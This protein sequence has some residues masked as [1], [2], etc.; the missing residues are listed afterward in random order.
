MPGWKLLAGPLLRRADPKR[1]CVWIATD[2]RL[3]C[4]VEIVDLGDADGPSGRPEVIGDS[5]EGEGTTEKS[6]GRE[7]GGQRTIRLGERL[8]VTLLSA[9]PYGDAFPQD[10]LLGYDLVIEG[11]RLADLGLLSGPERLAYGDLPLPTFFLASRT[12]SLLHGSCRNLGGSG[13]DALPG[14]DELLARHA[15]R[16]DLR[17]SILILDGDQV[18]ADHLPAPLIQHLTRL[19]TELMGWEE[20]IPGIPRKLAEIPVDG[21][22]ELATEKAGFTSQSAQNQLMAFGEY[23]ALSLVAWNRANWP[24]A[25]PPFPDSEAG[26]EDSPLGKA[27]EA[28]GHVLGLSRTPEQAYEEMVRKLERVREQVPAVRRLLANIPTYMIFDDHDMT[29]DLFLTR[30]W[31]DD[32]WA[33][34]TGRRI[35]ANGLA[36][37]WAFQ[38]WGS[39]PDLYP[40]AF[41]EAVCTHFAQR[42]SDEAAARAFEETLWHEAEWCFHVPV[43]P[44]T[45]VLDTRTRR[46]YDDAE[47]AARLINEEG[48]QSMARAAQR[49]GY[50]RGDP[51]VLVSPTPVVGYETVEG[52]Q[53]LVSRYVG[54]YRFDLE[55]WRAN[56]D[57]YTSFLQ[58][59]ISEFAPENVVFLAGD[60][61]YGFT[62]T[63]TFTW[64]GYT[65]PMLQLTSSALKNTGLAL[66][67]VEVGSGLAG[68]TDRH[69]GWDQVAEDLGEAESGAARD[70]EE[71]GD[72]GGPGRSIHV[73]RGTPA[74]MP[75]NLPRAAVPEAP[76]ATEGR[77]TPHWQ[78]ART[79]EPTWGF[80]SQPIVGE[81]NLG[82]VRFRDGNLLVHRLLI[83][84][85]GGTRSSTA[86]AHMKP[87]PLVV[88]PAEPGD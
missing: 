33:S 67:V 24:E 69:F 68:R 10:R 30:K 16:L 44:V 39:D 14:G 86:L 83:P 43:Q 3:S 84:T 85:E 32:V 36:A 8:Y 27:R 73:V 50:R 74:E 26:E 9:Y 59:L 71:D 35:I 7:A 48:L 66:K 72:A 12:L 31:K 4:R 29:D 40:D 80:G 19:G 38:C 28:A 61:H 81:N 1:I 64:R 51:L 42:G 65:L 57:G 87:G 41:I 18:Y 22:Q 54:P 53:E 88:T 46:G 11:R 55:S 45:I 13:L 70:R 49:A 5:P 76:G 23:A 60:V 20:A 34:P 78:D 47:G 2:A 37:A 15:R 56:I 75:A 21:R 79:F 62:I 58:F 52:M 17:P 6:R 63:A 25:L 77:G 82:L